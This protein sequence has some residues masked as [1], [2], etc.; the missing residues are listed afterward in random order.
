VILAVAFG[1]LSAWAAQPPIVT[2]P[3][4]ARQIA[5]GNR[6]HSGNIETSKGIRADG[7][8]SAAP[9]SVNRPPARAFRIGAETEAV[10]PAVDQTSNTPSVAGGQPAI[11]PEGSDAVNCRPLPVLQGIS[12]GRHVELCRVDQVNVIE[13]HVIVNN[14]GGRMATAGSGTPEIGTLPDRDL[15]S[16]K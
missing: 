1:G 13:K 16:E 4:A 8:V 9:A 12:A 14:F 10:P 11:I 15:H 3:F 5:H 6:A 2:K 7:L